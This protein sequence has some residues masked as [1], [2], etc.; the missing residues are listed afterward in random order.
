MH[1]ECPDPLGL[2]PSGRLNKTGDARCGGLPEKREVKFQARR[3]AE[4][5]IASL[6]RERSAISQ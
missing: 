4:L 6:K 2:L 5:E 3:M 1:E